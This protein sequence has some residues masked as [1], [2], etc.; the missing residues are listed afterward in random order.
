MAAEIA[1]A[2]ELGDLCGPF[3]YGVFGEFHRN[4]PQETAGFF[5]VWDTV[6]VLLF[7]SPRAVLSRS[8]RL[9]T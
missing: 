1:A 3:W 6:R 7:V 8:I 2:F 5:T 4:A 9:W